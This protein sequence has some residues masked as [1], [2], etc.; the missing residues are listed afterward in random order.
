MD[1]RFAAPHTINLDVIIPLKFPH[2]PVLSYIRQYTGKLN[3]PTCS[4]PA[5]IYS[6]A[7]WITGG[8]GFIMET[9]VW[10]LACQRYRGG[11]VEGSLE[12]VK[13]SNSSSPSFRRG[14]RCQKGERYRGESKRDREGGEGN[15]SGGKIG[16]AVYIMGFRMTPQYTNAIFLVLP[17]FLILPF[18]R[19]PFSWL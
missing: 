11:R 4:H 9:T 2:D 6:F 16:R 12:A 8:D 14:R 1:V 13:V 19:P 10:V 3:I 15:E 5:A 7:L 18:L 17:N